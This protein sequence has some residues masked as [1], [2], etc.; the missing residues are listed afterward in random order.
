[1][2][3]LIVLLFI[4]TLLLVYG[5]DPVRNRGSLRALAVSNG[6]DLI[7]EAQTYVPPGYQGRTLPSS[8]SLVRVVAIT[9]GLGNEKNLN[10]HWRKDGLDVKSA[11]GAGKNAF[12]YRAAPS[13]GNLIEVTVTR[14]DGSI[15]ASGAARIP[16]AAPKI[17]FYEVKDGQIDYRRALKNLNLVTDQTKIIAEPFYFSLTDWLNHRLNFNWSA[18]QQKVEPATEDPRFLT[19]ITSADSGTGETVLDLKITNADHPLQTATAKL[20][21]SFGQ[22]GFGF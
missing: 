9:S 3:K 10:F 15:D 8:E 13:S 1:M 18:N 16:V 5:V 7:W 6:V 2:K 14:P 22:S 4:L 12:D 20:P 19:L 17:V 11:S 21:V